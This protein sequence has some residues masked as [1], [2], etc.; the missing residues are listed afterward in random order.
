MEKACMSAS[1]GLQPTRDMY[2]SR[3]TYKAGSTIIRNVCL[4]F[5]KTRVEILQIHHFST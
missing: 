4:T 1:S 5:I 2:G 3:Q